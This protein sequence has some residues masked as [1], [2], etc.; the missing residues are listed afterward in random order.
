[1]FHS[2][3]LQIPRQSDGIHPTPD[4]YAAWASAI[5]AWLMPSPV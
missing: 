3:T 1:M 5:W 2:E 4:G